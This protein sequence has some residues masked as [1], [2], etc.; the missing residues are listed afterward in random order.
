MKFIEC[1]VFKKQEYTSA[2]ENGESTVT[3]SQLSSNL[4]EHLN[5]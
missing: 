1:A 5:H 3:S 4:E 2:S